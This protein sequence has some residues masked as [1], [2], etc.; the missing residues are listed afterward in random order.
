MS[1]KHSVGL[2][3]SKE[4]KDFIKE[5]GGRGGDVPVSEEVDRFL[6]ERYLGAHPLHAKVLAWDRRV[7]AAKASAEAAQAQLRVL[8][9]EAEKE[10]G[11]PLSTMRV[12]VEEA[13]RKRAA[14]MERDK[15]VERWRSLQRAWDREYNDPRALDMRKFAARN[16]KEASRFGLTVAEAY[17]LLKGRKEPPCLS[18]VRV[19]TV[20]GY[21]PAAALER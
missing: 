14:K 5:H 17:S 8:E 21:A 1:D 7:Q 2:R 16:E 15:L 13:L 9:A 10:L 12:E 4:V 3:L 11:L 20:E 6:K 18:L 19:G